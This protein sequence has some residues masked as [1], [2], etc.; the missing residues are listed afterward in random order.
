MDRGWVK[1]WRKEKDSLI[2]KMPP[3]YYK[4]WRYLIMEV[5]HSENIIPVDGKPFKILPG[6]KLTSLR[7]IA[8]DCAYYENNRLVTPSTSTISRILTFFRQNCMILWETLNRKYS[9]ITICNFDKYQGQ[10][11]E[12]L[13]SD[14]TAAEQ[15][16]KEKN[17][18]NI[19]FFCRHF[20]V[21]KEKHQKYQ[22]AY[23]GLDIK[24]EYRKMD[25][26]L[27]SNP[28]KRKTPK[29]YPRFINNWLS[30]AYR[31]QKNISDWR[32]QLPD[33]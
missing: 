29:G 19:I 27:E 16:K 28:K 7:Q 21:T 13:N 14:G 24:A 12:A 20:S 9:L 4:V 31:D 11:N 15:N 1:Q 22:R 32:D 2:F 10:H 33:L 8:I 5:N 18:K 3:L 6:Q 26:W 17:E 30:N 23:P 25:A